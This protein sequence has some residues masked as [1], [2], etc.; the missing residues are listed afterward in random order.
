MLKMNDDDDDGDFSNVTNNVY[1]SVQTQTEAIVLIKELVSRQ[2]DR[3]Q[4]DSTAPN[5]STAGDGDVKKAFWLLLD[6]SNQRTLFLKL[7]KN[8]LFWPR[9]K[10]C[11][12]SPPF[13]F[14]RPQD[15]DV[16]RAGG[17]TIGRANM[18]SFTGVSS[19]NEIGLGQ[20]SDS[21]ERRFKIVADDSN[22]K[23]KLP[24]LRALG[25]KR[26]VVDVKLPRMKKID[27][28]KILKSS[29]GRHPSVTFPRV[30]ERLELAPNASLRGSNLVLVVRTIEAPKP[31]S[32]VARIFGTSN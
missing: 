31:E 23:N 18:S 2:L 5:Q 9:V 16:L 10:S 32:P 28:F 25:A 6:S 17:I 1:D 19:S 15:N 29:N 8:Q 13:S 27:R 22:E 7:C 21:S 3:A 11:I 26:V 20:F 30:G 4:Q 14:L 12:G 24:H